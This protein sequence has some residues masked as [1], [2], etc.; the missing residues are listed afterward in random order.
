MTTTNVLLYYRTK[1][2]D[3]ILLCSCDTD[4]IAQKKKIEYYTEYPDMFSFLER[5][6]TQII[7]HFKE[8]DFK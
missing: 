6:E 3:R 4:N 2:G 8:E 1:S 7:I 5:F